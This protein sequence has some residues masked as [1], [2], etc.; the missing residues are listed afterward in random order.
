MRWNGGGWRGDSYFAFRAKNRE[1]RETIQP[2]KAPA[3]L[4]RV[5]LPFTEHYFMKCNRLGLLGLALTSALIC[6][7]AAYAANAVAPTP[8]GSI[9]RAKAKRAVELLNGAVDYLKN[10]GPEK[11]FAAFNDAKGQFVN[12]PYYVYVVG[13]DGFMHANG[14]SQI[15]LAGKNAM[16]LPMTSMCLPL[17]WTMASTALQVRHRK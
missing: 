10:N 6:A 1:C 9:E 5:F 17:A 4:A 12:G 8:L 15:A 3:S 2:F 16:D 14:G 13:L 7:P 11:Y